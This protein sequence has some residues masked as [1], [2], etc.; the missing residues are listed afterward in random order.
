MTRPTFEV[1]DLLINGSAG[2][3]GFKNEWSNENTVDGSTVPQ[4]QF[5]NLDTPAGAT[6]GRR[7]RSV[8][9]DSPVVFVYD[10]Q[11]L[12]IAFNDVTLN[13]QD[14]SA[15]AR[16][17]VDVTEPGDGREGAEYL[18]DLI[19]VLENIREANTAP[20]SGVFN[21]EYQVMRLV[22][23]D[24]TPTAFAEHWRAFYDL[25]LSAEGVI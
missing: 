11:A 20:T 17:Q 24:K 23:I 22:Q 10:D 25:E 4:P 3:S 21:S 13:S 6:S 18:V 5:I 14:Y 15:L 2:N 19:E 8:T 12:D 1:G 9:T 7:S 16:L